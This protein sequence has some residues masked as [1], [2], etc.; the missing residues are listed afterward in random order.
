MPSTIRS[1][2][3]DGSDA[4]GE[5]STGRPPPLSLTSTLITPSSEIVTSTSV[6]A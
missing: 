6:Q 2:R 4:V 3:P 1:P 5:R